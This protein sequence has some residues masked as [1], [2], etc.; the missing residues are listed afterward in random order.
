MSRCTRV[1]TILRNL[2]LLNSLEVVVWCRGGG[3]C[4]GVLAGVGRGGGI[5]CGGKRALYLKEGVR[6]IFLVVENLPPPAGLKGKKPTG[7]I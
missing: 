2:D 7:G 1:R 4:G 5:V 3:L 6:G